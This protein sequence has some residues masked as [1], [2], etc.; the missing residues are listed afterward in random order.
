[1]HRIAGL[2]ACRGRGPRRR[3]CRQLTTSGTTLAWKDRVMLTGIRRCR[4]YNAK[5]WLKW[6]TTYPN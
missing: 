5:L 4:S 6:R 2:L 3:P 1:M